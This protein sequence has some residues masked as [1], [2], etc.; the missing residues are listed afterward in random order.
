[1]YYKPFLFKFL[2]NF[3]RK[4][5][6]IHSKNPLNQIKKEIVYTRKKYKRNYSVLYLKASYACNLIIYKLT[7]K[8]V[9]LCTNQQSLSMFFPLI[10]LSSI[11]EWDI[12]GQQSLGAFA[13][14]F[15]L[16]GQGNERD[17]LVLLSQVFHLELF[18]IFN[19][20]FKELA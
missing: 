3:L 19:V 8:T 11:S 10:K 1:M 5:E 14:G 7:G 15:A 17:F 18:L 13:L 12:F 9:K 6:P 2:I 20:N 16:L 4:K